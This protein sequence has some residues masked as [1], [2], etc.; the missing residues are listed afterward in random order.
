MN[1]C[2]FCKIAAKQ[3]KSYKV[4]ENDKVYAFLD[5]NPANKYHTLII[6][7]NHY[8][9]IF[10]IPE[11]ELIEFIKVV[12]KVVDLYKDK[13]GIKNIQIF[14]SSGSEAQQDVFHIHF[15]IVPRHDG[16]GQDVVW[17]THPEYSEDFESLL[18]KIQ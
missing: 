9:N 6:P 10:D 11:D 5:I 15:H 7:K 2:I 18:Q 16:D 17:K 12:K 3:E 4:Y 1:N 14:N 13:L 8:E